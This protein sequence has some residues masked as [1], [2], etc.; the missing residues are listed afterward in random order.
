MPPREPS[1]L[2]GGLAQ[3]F[4]SSAG[5]WPTEE[6]ASRMIS[7]ESMQRRGGLRRSDQPFAHMVTTPKIVQGGTDFK[8]RLLGAEPFK[9]HLIGITARASALFG[10]THRP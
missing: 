8:V 2:T 5:T 9:D 3:A 10:G 7:D 1:G 6:T 4:H